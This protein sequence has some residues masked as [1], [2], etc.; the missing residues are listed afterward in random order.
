MYVSTQ[1]ELLEQY[2]FFDYYMIYFN[3]TEHQTITNGVQL[4]LAPTVP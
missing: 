4:I 1:L 3:A 2:Y